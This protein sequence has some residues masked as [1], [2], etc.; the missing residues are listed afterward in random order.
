MTL[1]AFVVEL[2]KSM[3]DTGE[4]EIHFVCDYDEQFK[5]AL[6]DYIHFHPGRSAGY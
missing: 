3:H 1:K 5:N 2:A 6:P 4:F